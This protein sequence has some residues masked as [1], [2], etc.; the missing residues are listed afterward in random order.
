[1]RDEGVMANQDTQ[2]ELAHTSDRYTAV[3]L[4]QL[5]SQAEQRID[6]PMARTAFEIME[7]RDQAE[8][9]ARLKSLEANFKR[10]TKRI[11]GLYRDAHQGVMSSLKMFRTKPLNKSLPAL[12]VA[13]E[14]VEQAIQALQEWLSKV[15]EAGWERKLEELEGYAVELEDHR[16][17]V[18]AAQ[19]TIRRTRIGL[20][21]YLW[22]MVLPGMPPEQPGETPPQLAFDRSDLP[23]ERQRHILE[24]IWVT[25]DELLYAHPGH[26]QARVWREWKTLVQKA[27][28]DTRLGIPLK[29]PAWLERVT[30]RLSGLALRI[31]LLRMRR[32]PGEEP[33]SAEEEA[34]E[35]FPGSAEE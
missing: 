19:E 29:R 34:E 27:W 32:K 20:V 26:E 7:A 12:L 8:F 18:R 21:A 23:I 17:A 4:D 1:M 33:E 28:L 6:Y 3:F 22:P 15:R 25:C 31:R 14:Q 24:E 30:T 5:F 16:D 35:E 13:Q 10:E 2:T 11:Q 9:E